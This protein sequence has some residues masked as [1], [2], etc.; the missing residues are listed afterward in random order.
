MTDDLKARAEFALMTIRARGGSAAAREALDAA[1]KAGK[2]AARQAHA[3][4]LIELADALDHEEK[5]A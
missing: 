2:A 3:Q 5:G 4:T 1:A